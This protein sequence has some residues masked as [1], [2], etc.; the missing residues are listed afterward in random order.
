MNRTSGILLHPTS[1]PGPFGIGDLGPQ[2]RSFVDWLAEAGQGL[3]QVLPLGPTGFGDS[4]YQC[5]SAFAGN[6][7]LLSPQLLVEEGWLEESWL[8]DAPVFPKERVDYGRVMGWKRTL[9]EAAYQG[10]RDRAGAGERNAFAL[11]TAQQPWL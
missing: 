4:P 2:A 10:F 6:P 5:L 9:I 3:W 1:L 8:T 11:F 7:L